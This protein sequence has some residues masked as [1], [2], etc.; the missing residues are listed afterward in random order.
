MYADKLS[1][2]AENLLES[3]KVQNPTKLKAAIIGYAAE[4]PLPALKLAAQTPL[5]GDI[6]Q[7]AVEEIVDDLSTEL[8]LEIDSVDIT[9]KDVAKRVDQALKKFNYGINSAVLSKLFKV[10]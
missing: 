3:N 4:L 8:D 2:I 5:F 1:A 7:L 9:E 10:V 6:L